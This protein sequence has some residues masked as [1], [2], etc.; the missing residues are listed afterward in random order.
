MTPKPPEPSHIDRIRAH[1]FS[2]PW[3]ALGTLAAIVL[4]CLVAIPSLRWAIFDATWVGESRQAC[5]ENRGAC[6]PFV[7][8]RLGQLLFGF[9]PA[10]EYYRIFATGLLIVSQAWIALKTIA[11]RHPLFVG[12]LLIGLP[13]CCWHLLVGDVLGLPLVPT[14]RW[15]GLFLTF[16]VSGVGIVTSLPLGTLLAL[17]RRSSLPVVRALSTMFIE[18][19]R[20]VPLITVLFMSSVMLPIFFPQDVSFNKLLRALIAVSLF[21]SAY[22]AEVVRGGLQAIPKGQSEAGASLG[23]SLWQ[24]QFL[25]VLPQALKHVIPGIVNTFIGLFKDTTLVAVIGMLDLLGIVQAAMTDPDWL[26]YTMEG[27]AFAALC[28]WI[29]C[30]G[31]SKVSQRLERRLATERRG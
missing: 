13:L 24:I 15:G 5:A 4:I 14:D 20:G 6:W 29:F 11:G 21:S 18:L 28:F 3:N 7:T 10:A 22:M 27:Y 31:M 19:W 30:W 23:L 2:S 12:W 17:G 26:G 25:I 1:L 16:V 9:Y 8:G